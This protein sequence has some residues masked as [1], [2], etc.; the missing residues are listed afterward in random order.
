MWCHVMTIDANGVQY[1]LVGTEKLLRGSL[2]VRCNCWMNGVESAQSQSHRI[3]STQSLL[4]REGDWRC[5]IGV[6]GSD[7]HSGVV[8]SRACSARPS[9]VRKNSRA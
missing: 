8:S 2:S 7:F 1:S 4:T 3:M 9:I 5:T 6:E